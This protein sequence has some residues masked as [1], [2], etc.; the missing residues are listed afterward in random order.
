VSDL[1][2]TSGKQLDWEA[3]ERAAQMILKQANDIAF[4]PPE[5]VDIHR[6]RAGY[7]CDAIQEIVVALRLQRNGASR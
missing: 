1:K 5:A 2:I 4:C 6:M 3:V 7:V